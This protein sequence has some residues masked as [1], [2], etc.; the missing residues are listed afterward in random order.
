MK[1]LVLGLVVVS[2]IVAG[3]GVL[4][5]NTTG[6][7]YDH[8][9]WAAYAGLQGYDPTEN[10]TPGGCTDGDDNDGD[11]RVDCDDDD[12]DNV[13][14]C[15]TPAPT[16]SFMGIAALMVILTLIGFF[17]ITRRRSQHG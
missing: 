5:W 10:E 9:T 8:F 11:G 6:L 1:R 7:S 12:C 3:N 14:P 13:V 4:T 2:L 15:V 17:G 16:V